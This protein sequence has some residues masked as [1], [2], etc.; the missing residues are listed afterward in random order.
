MNRAVLFDLDGTLLTTGGAGRKAM[1]LAL[2][3]HG[4]HDGLGA[5]RLDGMTDRAIVREAARA[6]R[7]PC[8]EEAIDRALERYLQHLE[9]NIAACTEYVV[10]PGVDAAVQALRARGAAVGLGTGNVER[11][12]RIKLE[13][14]GLNAHLTFG[15]F[16][17]DAEDRA[18]LLRAGVRRAEALLGTALPAA[19]VW[20]VGD[21]PKDVAAARRIGA[22]VLA[23][24][25]GHYD[26]AA[27]RAC[28]PDVAA[29]DLTQP[30]ALAALLN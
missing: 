29:T 19:E 6:H 25:T 30:E 20:V 13:R 23:V 18:E 3:E 4:L 7:L 27:L 8:A 21:T 9:R 24:A 1:D 17:S 26:L 10:L 12:A 11:G 22:R 2:R 28:E 5:M 15:G 14:S 16:G